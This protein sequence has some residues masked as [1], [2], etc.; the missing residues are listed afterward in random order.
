MSKNNEITE[1]F[2]V[3]DKEKDNHISTKELKYFMRK[4]AQVNISSELAEAM[5]NCA[6]GDRDGL[7]TFDD[8]EQIYEL[9][10]ME[11][12]RQGSTTKDMKESDLSSERQ[13]S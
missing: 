13:R 5:I 2:N 4:V 3:L 8:F 9:V 12:H 10:M 1:A 11:K 7:V 6:D